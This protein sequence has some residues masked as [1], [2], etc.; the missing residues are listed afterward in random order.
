[1]VPKSG[2]NLDF[3]LELSD[4]GFFGCY[5]NFFFSLLN[6]TPELQPYWTKIIPKAAK[7]GP[8]IYVV[9]L[10]NFGFSDMA[11]SSTS[12]PSFGHF[13]WFFQVVRIH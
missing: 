12:G 8:F 4:Y 5:G 1:M 6:R 13:G 7:L 2:K 9:Q 10:S 3:L 11:R